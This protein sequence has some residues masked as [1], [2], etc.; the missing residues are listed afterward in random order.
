VHQV[1]GHEGGVAV[2]EIIVDAL[3]AAAGFG[4][5]VAGT[6]AGFTDPAGISLG[7]DGI[8]QVLQAVK[9]VLSA[10]LDT[11]FV[12]GDQAAAG[13]AIKAYWPCLFK[14]LLRA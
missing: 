13:F 14:I 9:D 4:V 2:G 10:M 11:V 3:E 12:A 5:A 6:G 7:R 8:A 1:P